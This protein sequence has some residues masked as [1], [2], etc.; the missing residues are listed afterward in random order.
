L[1]IL[2]V[3]NPNNDDWNSVRI[4]LNDGST[5]DLVLDGNKGQQSQEI[6]A[7]DGNYN[8]FY[9]PQSVFLTDNLSNTIQEYKVPM[10][11]I[12][13]RINEIFGGIF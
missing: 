4:I 2:Q 13:N 5:I 10:A 7:N 12:S 6:Q 11:K 1:R 9:N 8:L 3:T